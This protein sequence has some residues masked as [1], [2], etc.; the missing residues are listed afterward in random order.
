MV[1]A[2]LVELGEAILVL[3][4]ADTLF[5]IETGVMLQVDVKMRFLNAKR[6][7]QLFQNVFFV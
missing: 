3:G 6:L 1:D 7:S 5:V 2:V 4:V